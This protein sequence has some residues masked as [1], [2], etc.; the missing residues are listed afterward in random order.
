[1]TEEKIRIAKP[2]NDAEAEARVLSVLRSGRLVQGAL[3]KRFEEE[4]GQYLGSKHVVAVNSGTA[5]IHTALSVIMNDRTPTAPEVI[6]TPLS[7]SATANAIIHANC[8]PVFTDVNPETFNIDDGLIEENISERTIAIEPVDVFGL[9]TN[10]RTINAI[11]KTHSLA[12]VEDA[13]EAIGASHEGIKVGNIS[14]LTC[15]STYATKNIHSGEGGFITT[16]DDTFDAYMRTFRNQGQIAKYKQTILGYNY[17]MQET[18]A[19]IALSQTPKIDEINSRRR[20]NSKRLREGLSQINCLNFQQVKN[21]SEHAW[22][23]FA[24]TI[25]EKKAGI[26]RDR[27]VAKL[28]E[29]GVEADVAWPTPIHLQ[30][31]YR[32]RYNYREGDFPNAEQICKTVFQLPIQPDLTTTQ[33]DRVVATVS[34][35]V[36]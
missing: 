9:P 6:T 36:K 5:A 3:V 4:I 28:N 31:Y 2:Y 19:A 10:L 33:I 20:E 12:V 14:T 24:A 16:N 13:A 27:L 23:M 32:T 21:P 25:D 30:P 22:Y 7:F 8:K 29:S 18:S 26:S 17:R 11:A 34:S 35:L 1:L 15:F